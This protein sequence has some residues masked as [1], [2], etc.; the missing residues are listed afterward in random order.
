M[1]E[2]IDSAEGLPIFPVAKDHKDRHGR[3]IDFLGF[4]FYHN[5]TRQRKRIKQNLCRKVAKLRK[6]KKP[7]TNE[8]FK[9]RIASWWGW[10]KHSDS[11]YFI[12]KLNSKIKPYEIKFK[13]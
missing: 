11:E 5:E 4:V 10:A 3:G 9:Q 7:L 12:N 1:D 2:I 8:E 13:R 6:R